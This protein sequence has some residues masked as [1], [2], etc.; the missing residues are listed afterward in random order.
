MSGVHTLPLVEEGFEVVMA[1]NDV[2]D[3]VPAGSELMADAPSVTPINLSPT[4]TSS[5]DPPSAQLAMAQFS[6]DPA[7]GSSALATV[8]G[9]A[10]G[11][12]AGAA[13]EAATGG[14]ITPLVP[15]IAAGT[16][17]VVAPLI[18]AFHPNQETS[19]TIDR[20]PTPAVEPKKAS[21]GLQILGDTT[22]PFPAMA[23]TPDVVKKST[24]ALTPAYV[25]LGSNSIETQHCAPTLAFEYPVT[26]VTPNFVSQ[27]L[28]FC[29]RNSGMFSVAGNSYCVS[30]QVVPY[31]LSGSQRAAVTKRGAVFTSHNI[32][33]VDNAVHKL[34]VR[35][36]GVVE[37]ERLDMAVLN[38]YMNGSSANSKAIDASIGGE[39]RAANHYLIREIAAQLPSLNTRADNSM[40][41]A[42]G[43]C[44][45][46]QCDIATT[47][48]RQ[49]QPVAFGE[50]QCVNFLNLDDANVTANTWVPYFENG[51]IQM[52]Q[53]Q[54]WDAD[55]LQIIYW[56]AK[57]G[58]RWTG[59]ANARTNHNL[60]IN[61]PSIQFLLIKHGAADAVP[62]VAAITS[63]AMYAFLQR[64]ANKRNE[65]DAYEK[66]LYIAL[67]VI[68]VRYQVVANQAYHLTADFNAFHVNAPAPRDY[69]ILLRMLH[70]MFPDNPH[71]QSEMEIFGTASAV[72]RT[73]LAAA[74]SALKSAAATT[75]MT[76]LNITTQGLTNYATQAA[77]GDQETA[78][79]AQGFCVASASV[80][81]PI[82]VAKVRDAFFALTGWAVRTNLMP[83]MYWNGPQGGNANA[84][85]SFAGYNANRP[86]TFWNPLVVDDF[87]IQRPLE[88]GVLA[89]EPKINFSHDCVSC[90]AAASQGVYARRGDQSYVNRVASS[91]PFEY[92]AYGT[93][94]AN[95]IFQML[96]LNN[97]VLHMETSTWDYGFDA[98]WTPPVQDNV[99]VYDAD[100]KIFQPCTLMTYTYATTAVNAAVVLAN[101]M[102]NANSLATFEAWRG[103]AV[104]RIG[105]ML[106]RRSTD[107][108][109]TTFKGL[110]LGG[111]LSRIPMA[112]TS[113]QVANVVRPLSQAAGSDADQ[114]SPSGNPP[115]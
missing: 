64:M 61:W 22:L 74:Y 102:G 45:A 110:G 35:P 12:A 106:H 27:C 96:Q 15:A 32:P 69:N 97:A 87:L 85:H 91:A 28:G 68:G 60:Y 4:V 46:L 80:I 57:A 54:D 20:K 108:V 55:D 72:T 48:A 77:L 47:T 65:W 8:T 52:L 107:T 70:I 39:F 53:R 93:S 26:S 33:F 103:D 37:K 100:L 78:I 42:K 6:K 67:D 104:G 82:A 115:Q 36:G 73:N 66:G 76:S 29:Q 90:S 89:P 19:V 18:D 7:L 109:L 9:V 51:A 17:A 111:L 59:A 113:Q 16:E 23:P 63:R 92:V 98:G 112:G 58:H 94:M 40:I 5:L 71:A 88:W 114:A 95:A 21:N 99:A 81:E 49:L 11:I 75:L 13:A 50:D 25:K 44:A 84:V 2:E 62:A 56:L 105:F 1:P 86:P 14:A 30:S 79:L 10:A 43:I 83:G 41:Y 31:Y 24:V 38:L 34:E 3:A 101:R